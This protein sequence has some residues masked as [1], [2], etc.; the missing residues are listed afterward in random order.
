MCAPQ[1]IPTVR[2]TWPTT[3]SALKN[4][5]AAVFE[6]LPEKPPHMAGHWIVLIACGGGVIGLVVGAF[7]F[8]EKAFQSNAVLFGSF[9]I[10]V[11]L[12]LVV[13]WKWVMP[14]RPPST[15]PSDT[16]RG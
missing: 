16:D 14:R 3:G 8:G 15:G 10:G 13:A 4:G 6:P 2:R 11:L 1:V 9:G 7:V 5:E 12:G